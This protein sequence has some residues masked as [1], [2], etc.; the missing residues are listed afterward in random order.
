MAQILL[1]QPKHE[2]DQ[3]QNL[4]DFITYARNELT[5]YED[6]GGFQSIRWKHIYDNGK[7]ASMLF[8]SLAPKGSKFG[9]E[10][11]QPFLDFARAY[12]RDKQTW[13]AVNPAAF[14]AALKGIH[15][16]LLDVHGV[17]DIL[18]LDSAALRRTTE[19]LSDR[20]SG[21]V[22][23]RVGQQIE[24]LINFLK[25]SKI[26]VTI[27]S[28][29]SPWGRT[30][31]RAIGASKDDRAWQS[32]RLLTSHQISCLAS[33]F[34]MA[35]TP[36]EKYY[37]ALSV[38]LMFAPS[39]AGELNFLATDCLFETTAYTRELNKKTGS[40]ESKEVSVL[41]IRWEAAKDGG[42]MPKPVHPKLEPTVRL[43]IDRLVE[44]GKPARKAAA[45][46]IENPELFYRHEGC[47]AGLAHGED[48]PLT[49]EEV[50]AAISLT[51]N[52]RWSI[53]R[54]E[55]TDARVIVDAI[56]KTKWVREFF[57]GKTHITYRDLARLSVKKYREKFP[58]WPFVS[59][60]QL[61]VSKVLC[62]V[63][64]Y[65]LHAEFAPRQNSWVLPDVNLLND[66]LGGRYERTGDETLFS[67]LG[68]FDTD[69]SALKISSHQVR[70]WLST[71]AE[72]GEM[73]SLDLAMYAGRARIEDNL[74]YDLR[75]QEERVAMVREVMLGSETPGGLMALDQINHNVPVTYQGLGYKDRFG[76]VQVTLWGLCELDWSQTPCT[77]AGDCATCT[78]HACIK[79]MPHS[80]ERLVKLEQQHLSEFELALNAYHDEYSGSEGWVIFHAKRLAIVRTLIQ[81]LRDENVPDGTI[82]RVPQELD[83]SSTQIALQERGLKSDLIA[84]DS[85]VK[86]V[87]ELSEKIFLA[88]LEDANFENKTDR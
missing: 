87:S 26:N 44:I 81:V 39:R 55:S 62:L 43:A 57:D 74:A 2:R 63:R 64:E 67:R 52:E 66:A 84:T 75:P 70:S 25:T 53:A 51:V 13:S 58:S 50:F 79:G 54:R 9:T 20:L 42:L 71:M 47:I 41:N 78:E 23:Y 49:L 59:Q 38:L 5:L 24:L 73:D 21:S 77:K 19:L 16:S 28:F 17:A 33:T 80:L 40:V 15:D 37:S 86:L 72:R 12:V 4:R 35:K 56:G 29:K 83:Q 34:S 76:P 3:A 18:I 36:Y 30:R 60:V 1:F 27:P 22:L 31:E 45:W 46:A 8:S 48:D 14:M 65:E 69:G 85:A 82:I 68:L 11:Q 88:I 7:S 6:Q 10:M 32:E 61:P